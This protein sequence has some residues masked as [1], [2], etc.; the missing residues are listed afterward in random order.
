MNR[1]STNYH[2]IETY[3][4]NKIS[5]SCYDNKKHIFEDIYS[6]LSYLHKYTRESYQNN[7]TE[8]RQFI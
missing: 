7:F 2:N 4:I 6:R 8:Y 1:I 5:L 3:R